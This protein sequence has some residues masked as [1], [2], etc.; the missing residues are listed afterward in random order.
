[1]STAT[2][3]ILAL[4]AAGFTYRLCVGRTLADR[5]SAMNGIVLT[6]MGAIA[7]YAVRSGD[8]EYLPALVALAL[9]SPIGNGMVA[10]YIERRGG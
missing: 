2:F 9:V 4:A 10:R 1:M 8:G 5:V 6:A 7:T 3:V